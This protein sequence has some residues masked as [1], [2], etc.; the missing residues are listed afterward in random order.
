MLSPADRAIAAGHVRHSL[1]DHERALTQN[2]TAL[3]SGN[4]RVPGV[5]WRR[6]A[7][8]VLTVEWIDGIPIGDRERLLAHSDRDRTYTYNFEKT[9]FDVDNYCATL[10]VTPVTD[11]HVVRCFLNEVRR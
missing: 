6:T 5:D 1:P 8:R 7:Q 10:R 3:E 9:P 11:G 4:L 2:D